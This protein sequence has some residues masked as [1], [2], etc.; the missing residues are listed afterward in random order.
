[1]FWSETVLT[2]LFSLVLIFLNLTFEDLDIVV[3]YKCSYLFK[4]QENIKKQNS[5]LVYRGG[6]RTA[7]TS[8]MERFVIIANGFQPLNIITKL[9]ILDVAAVLDPLLS[10]LLVKNYLQYF[11]EEFLWPMSNKALS[12]LNLLYCCYCLHCTVTH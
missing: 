6:S 8:E 1:M 9:S 5:I 12:P 2:I 10:V 7:A 4:I 11:V 3:D